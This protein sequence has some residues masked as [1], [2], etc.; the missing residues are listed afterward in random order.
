[1]RS[2]FALSFLLLALFSTTCL[3]NTT[4]LVSFNNTS[5]WPNNDNEDYSLGWEFSVSGSVTVTDLGYNYFGVPLNNSHLVGIFDSTGTL[6]GSVTVTN[7]STLLN[8]YLYTA[9]GA[10]LTLTTGDY[11]ISGTTLGLN[12]GWIY[13][14]SSIVTAPSI[15]YVDSWSTS[16]DGGQLLFPSSDTSGSRQYLEVNFEIPTASESGTFALVG[17]ELLA[18]AI[19]LGRRRSRI[20]TGFVG[21]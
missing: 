11:W 14:A 15:T 19:W 10:P 2:R 12:D 1:M 8:G 9:L 17:L 7:S 13:Q 21:N 5:V 16:G 6:L 18:G 3:A 4:G 20:G